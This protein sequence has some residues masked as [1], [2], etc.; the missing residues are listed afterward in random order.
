MRKKD[1]LIPLLIIF[2]LLFLKAEESI[3]INPLMENALKY[4][5]LYINKKKIKGSPWP[6]ITIITSIEAM[7]EQSAAIFFAYEEH[8]EFIPDL[9]I[10]KPIKYISPT[11]LHIYFEMNLPWPVKNSKF[12]TNNIISK[13]KGGGYKIRWEFV[14]SNTTKESYGGVSFLPYK[15]KTMLI[16]KNYTLPKSGLAGIFKGSAFKK[17]KKTVLSIKRRIEFITKNR[18]DKLPHYIDNLHRALKGEYIYTKIVE[19]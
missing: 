9:L 11:K 19:K 1:I 15:N 13:I 7:P 16:Y 17:V 6:E 18:K 4:G 12:I 3:K 14:K 5:R 2:P 8:K 10:S